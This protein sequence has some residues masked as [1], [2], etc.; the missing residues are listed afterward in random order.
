M[1]QIL[2]SDIIGKKG[3]CVS[4]CFSSERSLLFMYLNKY[5]IYLET[6]GHISVFLVLV[7]VCTEHVCETV[8][9]TY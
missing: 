2:V 4:F 9:T 3:M 5:V 8:E 1:L 6:K 7:S